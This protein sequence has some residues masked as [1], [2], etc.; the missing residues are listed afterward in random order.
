MLRRN[1]SNSSISLQLGLEDLLG[2]L[3]FA[4][5]SGDLSRIALLAYC[6]VRRWARVAGEQELE[7]Q[8]SDIVN[9]SPHS[10]REEFIAQAD[11]LIAKLEQ[12]RLRIVHE[13]STTQAA[14]SQT[15]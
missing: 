14:T 6:E 2:D 10:N 11:S 9:N 1:M 5:R 4:R 3:Q 7:T 12:A 13:L 15:N 8:S